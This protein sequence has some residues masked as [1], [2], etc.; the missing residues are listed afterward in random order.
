MD[1]AMLQALTQQFKEAKEKDSF[2]REHG[3]YHRQLMKRAAELLRLERLESLTGEELKGFLEDLDAWLGIRFKKG[4]WEKLLGPQ[5]ERLPQV[6]EA[7]GDLIRRAEA[8]LTAEDFNALLKALPGIGPAFL[9][10]ILSCRFPDRYWMWNAQNQ[11]FFHHLGVDVKGSLPRGRKGDQGAEY[12]AAKGPMD[13]VRAALAEA[14]GEP[15]DYQ[16]TDLFMYW[17]NQQTQPPSLPQDPWVERIA[18]WREQFDLD[19][20]V[21]IRREGEAR[22][23]ALLEDR[24][25]QFTE[26]DLR[27]FLAAVGASSSGRGDRFM[28]TP[29]GQVEKIAK[30]LEAFNQWVERL[31]K[32]DESQVDEVLDAFWEAG[33]VEGAGISLPTIILYLRDPQRYNVWLPVMEQGLREASGFQPGPPRKAS[34]YRAYNEAVLAFRE[35]YGLEPQETDW[36][37]W[38]V[39]REPEVS[40]Q[41]FSG[42]T[43]DTFQFLQELGSLPLECC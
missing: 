11:K 20:E 6:R 42:F 35:R 23:R 28:P 38:A 1:K 16:F 31:W 17:A 8:G 43:D 26:E 32:A 22:A 9:S 40:L 10:E 41:L 36:I 7:L 12:M 21:V 13:E 14:L 18:E 3:E 25:G 2:V 5:G 4:F 29:Y 34:S 33:E 27:N 39:A 15:V 30:S 37:L 19:R 24:V